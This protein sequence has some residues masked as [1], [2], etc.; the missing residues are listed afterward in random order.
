[1]N[2]KS[3]L[4]AGAMSLAIVNL[5]SASQDVYMTG[6]TAARSAID[7]AFTTAGAVFQAAAATYTTTPPASGATLVNY[8]GTLVGDTVPTTVHCFWTGSE[9]GFSDL[10]GVPATETFYDD[11]NTG[12]TAPHS[13][14]IAMA[15]N[16][17]AY[18]KLTLAQQNTIEDSKVY[19]I[20]FEMV[21]EKGS[22]SHL[23]NCT[24]ECLLRLRA[25]VLHHSESLQRRPR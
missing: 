17:V 25:E 21:A 3:I 16:E 9:G 2:N 6:S 22:S 11:S 10:V 20:P 14:D 4:V 23:T 19:V 24:L 13:V 18:S 12:T 5:A 8:T 15:D 1:M 7:A